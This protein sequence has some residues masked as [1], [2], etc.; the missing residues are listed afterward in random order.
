MPSE[1]TA[2][3]GD[4]NSSSE[5]EQQQ[6]FIA[7]YAEVSKLTLY[8]SPVNVLL[9]F[10]PIGLLAERL[11]FSPTVVFLTNFF[12]IIP[13]ASIL[14]YATEELA[15]HVGQTVGGLLNATFG[16]AVEVIVSIIALRQNQITVVQASMLGSILSNILLVLGC[17]FVAGGMKYKSQT[18]NQTVA[19]T[20]S[21]LL[22]LSMI[23]LLLPAAFHASLSENADES[24]TLSFSRG[25]SIILLGVYCFY[26]FFQLKTHRDL[27][28]E[29]N[30]IA[31]LGVTSTIFLPEEAAGEDPQSLTSENYVT[32]ENPEE[33]PGSIHRRRSFLAS[34][35]KSIYDLD[36]PKHLSTI[37]SLIIL[38]LTTALVSFSADY[39]V[40]SI[41]SLVESSGLSKTFI[42]LILIPF[43]GNAA[44]HVTAVVVALK[45]KMDLAIGVAIGSSLQIALF[46]TPFL[47]LIGWVSDIPMSLFF[48]NYE[49]AVMFT[50][51]LITNYLILDGESNWLEGVMLLSTYLIIAISFYYYPD[52]ASQTLQAAAN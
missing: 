5:N 25:T 38:L 12:A 15:E 16:N 47:V 44:E 32:D 9:I 20:M 3:I 46:V 13:L 41:D 36:N 45:N 33:R 18:F 19:Q 17:C 10:V 7:H 35:P 49:T 26:L 42:G 4:N 2:L 27:F 11:G 52:S 48:S 23:G 22:A 29:E 50:A 34:R 1:T 28:D 24:I 8:S 43:V 6:S 40:S 21:S 37:D 30:G 14:A 51:V 31:E 39:L